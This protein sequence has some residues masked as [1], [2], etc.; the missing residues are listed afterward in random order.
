MPGDVLSIEG[1]GSALC[2]TRPARIVRWVAPLANK[3]KPPPR[4]NF[5][6]T[7]PVVLGSV[8]LRRARI[9]TEQ[10]VASPGDGPPNVCVLIGASEEGDERYAECAIDHYGRPEVHRRLL[11]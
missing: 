6:A 1:L 2:G 7:W 10:A 5:V 4:A 11:S 9:V 3:P 8:F